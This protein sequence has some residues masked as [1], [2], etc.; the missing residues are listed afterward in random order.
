[1]IQTLFGSLDEEQKPSFIERMKQAV[2]R[3]RESISSK[4]EGI[5]ALVRTVDESTLESLETAL[6][7]SDIGV[8]TTAEILAALRDRARRQAIQGGDELRELLKAQLRAILE[9]PILTK[10]T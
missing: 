5:A 3:T 4:I 1:M 2:S 8:Q 10:P 6:L 7:T 9:A